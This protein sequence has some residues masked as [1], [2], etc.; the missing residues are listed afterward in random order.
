MPPLQPPEQHWLHHE[1]ELRQ[2]GY[3]LGRKDWRGG[4]AV[5]L[6]EDP[7]STPS[8]HMVPHNHL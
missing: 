8:I 6:L 7:S 5:S 1:M 4:S 2:R 3:V